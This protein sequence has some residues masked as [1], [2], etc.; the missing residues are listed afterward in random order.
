[1]APATGFPELPREL[2]GR[3]E[4]G[5]PTEFRGGEGG[6]AARVFER[7]GGA[8]PLFEGPRI[9]EGQPITE[10]PAETSSPF[11]GVRRFLV[12]RDLYILFETDQ[13]LAIVD[14]HALHERV[15]YERLL[16][17]WRDGSVPIQGL[18]V[19]ALID[20]P[21]ADKELLLDRAED[22]ERCGLRIADFGGNTIKLEGYP[23]ALRHVDPK[24]LL[25]GF[26]ADLREGQTPTESEDLRER[27]HSAA[28]RSAIM[29][30]DRLTESE[31]ADLLEQAA[32]LD[33]P[34]N[35]PHGR[36]TVLN[37]TEAQLEHW[38]RRT[39]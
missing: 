16:K 15:I 11:R 8:A 7:S 20:L 30:G 1:M 4:P 29:S 12:V 37:F 31:I 21:P 3:S 17:Q 10:S 36:P 19:P 9:T 24:G 2:F 13:G 28:C 34:D 14:Q 6:N 35:C 39:L 5:V 33:Q 27:F 26:L 38:F 32:T 18:L 23:A 25:E 22:L